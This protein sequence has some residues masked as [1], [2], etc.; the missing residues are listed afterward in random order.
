VEAEGGEEEEEQGDD[1]LLAPHFAYGVSLPPFVHFRPLACAVALLR[2]YCDRPALQE[3]S[4]AGLIGPKPSSR[5][6][7]IGLACGARPCFWL[8]DSPHF[9]NCKGWDDG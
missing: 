2:A 4:P 3:A 9:R 5:Q 1:S 7:G 8:L 6:P